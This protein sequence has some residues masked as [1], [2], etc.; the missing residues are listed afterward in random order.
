MCYSVIRCLSDLVCV[1]LPIHLYALSPVY[2]SCLPISCVFCPCV[3]I[4]NC[5]LLYAYV[6]PVC[7]YVFSY[8]C[9]ILCFILY[10]LCPVFFCCLLTITSCIC[11]LLC[12]FNVFQKTMQKLPQTFAII[13]VC[14]PDN[15]FLNFFSVAS[16]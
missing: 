10:T 3:I 9:F 5:F 4:L 13:P 15:F 7:D 8:T 2:L 14:C 11:V 1:T 6:S 16:D 12:T